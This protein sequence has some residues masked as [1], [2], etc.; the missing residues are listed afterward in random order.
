MRGKSRT[1]A[2]VSCLALGGLDGFRLQWRF[3][4][5]LPS[6]AGQAFL[7]RCASAPRFDCNLGPRSAALRPQIIRGVG[8]VR[9]CTCAARP[10]KENGKTAR[11]DTLTKNYSTS[12]IGESTAHPIHKPAVILSRLDSRNVQLRNRISS[13]P[14]MYVFFF[15]TNALDASTRAYGVPDCMPLTQPRGRSHMPT[16]MGPRSEVSPAG[17]CRNVTHRKI[18]RTC[19]YCT[20]I[21]SHATAT[22]SHAKCTLCSPRTEHLD[23]C[24]LFKIAIGADVHRAEIEVAEMK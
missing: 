20:R 21:S 3:F 2:A 19:T 17:A 14:Y 16:W 6:D 24:S 15:P 4:I 23:S 22:I 12:I 1:G 11:A 5:F 13:P 7:S 10:A 8:W 9:Y 18:L